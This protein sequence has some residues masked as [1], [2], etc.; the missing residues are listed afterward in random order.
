MLLRVQTNAGGLL[1][2]A[3]FTR[4]SLL[5]QQPLYVCNKNGGR[6]HF[7]VGAQHGFLFFFP[8]MGELKR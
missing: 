5:G 8:S 7:L 3:P 2:C 1:L 6:D 4:R